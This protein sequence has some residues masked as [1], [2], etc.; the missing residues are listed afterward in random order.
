MDCAAVCI[1]LGLLV[2]TAAFRKRR[3]IEDR[4]FFCMI[5]VDL[6]TAVSDAGAYITGESD[7][8]GAPDICMV[9]NT[10]FFIGFVLF[11]LLW[12]IYI[13]QMNVRNWDKLRKWLPPISVPAAIIII[14]IIIN[15]FAGFLYSVDRLTN[16]YYEGSLYNLI[17]VPAL[18]YAFFSILLLFRV[19]IPFAV[20]ILILIAVRICLG[21]IL[22]GVSS[23][24]LISAMFLIYAHIHVMQSDFYKE[25]R[26]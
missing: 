7:F 21:V 26:P 15:H 17:L 19:D 4:L 16:V 5:I 12:F 22:R 9:C 2:Y 10:I 8:P 11:A 13:L 25:E 14:L 18:L 3:R 24:A 23:S 6:F 20:L 1:L